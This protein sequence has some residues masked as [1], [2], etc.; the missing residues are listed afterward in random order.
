MEEA[1]ASAPISEDHHTL[2]AVVLQGIQSVNSGLKEAF[3]GLLT[4]FKVSHVIPFPEQLL[5]LSLCY[6]YICSSPQAPDG[7]T[8]MHPGV[9]CLGVNNGAQRTV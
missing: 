7:F 6:L 9:K 4:G 3:R 5:I 1:L 8:K 2:M